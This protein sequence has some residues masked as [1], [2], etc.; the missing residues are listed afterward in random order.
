MKTIHGNPLTILG[1]PLKVGDKAPNF[2]AVGKG[3]ELKSL[4]DFKKDYVLISAVPSLDTSVCDFQTRNINKELAAFENVDFITISMDLPFAQERWCG[5]AGL[6]ITTL[7]DHRDADFA[8]KFGTYIKELRLLARSV[9][10]LD[11]DRKV[12]YV[13]YLDEMT[14]HPNYD[15]LVNFLKT[16]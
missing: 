4:S 9:F 3:L 2:S 16:L 14:N 7:S 13:E 6:D 11:K 5:A 15:N 1:T 12:I 8:Y 10:V